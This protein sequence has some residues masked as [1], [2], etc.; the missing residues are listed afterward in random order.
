MV[1]MSEQRYCPICDV[2]IT[3]S[4][5]PVD[6]VGTISS[7]AL[8]LS[9]DTLSP[10]I[11]LA[12]RYRIEELIGRGGM[13][14]VYRANQT[15]IGRMVALKTLNSDFQS[16]PKMLKRFHREARAAAALEHPN[17]VKIYDFGL[18]DET[19]IPFIAM[20]LLEGRPLN[21]A[22]SQDGLFNESRASQVLA[23]VA[24][25]LVEAHEKG[26]IHRDLKPDN[27]Y[28]RSLSDGT[29]SVKVLDFGIASI[30]HHEES[31]SEKL[32]RTGVP[33]GTPNYMSP[34]QSL[35]RS[36]DYRSDLYALGC[37]LYE[38]LSGAPPFSDEQPLA[39]L[40][41]QVQEPSP[42]LPGILV[43]GQHTSDN[44]KSLYH[45]LTHKEPNQRPAS[46]LG[47]ADAFTALSNTRTSGIDQHLQT[48]DSEWT[49]GSRVPAHHS[50][51]GFAT[52]PTLVSD[53]PK[54]SRKTSNMFPAAG[55]IRSPETALGLEA[56][57]PRNVQAVWAVALVA[58]TAAI[59]L[60][61][62]AQPG[63]DQGQTYTRQSSPNL[64]DT[65]PRVI[66]PVPIKKAI[67]ARDMGTKLIQPT[68][69]LHTIQFS[70]K[71]TGSDV[72]WRNKVIG[73][74]PFEYGF[75]PS[76]FPL[77]VRFERTG[78]EGVESVIPI[79]STSVKQDLAKSP[80]HL[81]TPGKKL[82]KRRRSTE[83][84]TDADAGFEPATW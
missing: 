59:L 50:S 22:L 74:T 62:V 9:R 43:D 77:I 19:G 24:M 69:P 78:F 44:L 3:E 2:W 76:D 54:L 21:V 82:K 60:W 83:V 10:G 29:E 40:M 14:Y 49:F 72:T 26:V 71:P 68:S 5:C 84:A 57:K 75:P 70:S 25:A 30:K 12:D 39:I 35:G 37:I 80:V 52:D 32:T 61:V 20:E 73:Q 4:V 8:S 46:T 7:E 45:A 58:M 1:D 79:K 47:V 67:I 42:N 64:V 15:S 65:S 16:D 34:E 18:D 36:V 33:L 23:G 27:V 28:V 17:V 38:L 53:E 55:E 11:I 31:P 56:P 6:G 63:Q 41:S 81:R 51:D 48:L 66:R 13:G